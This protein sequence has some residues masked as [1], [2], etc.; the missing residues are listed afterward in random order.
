MAND[1]THHSTLEAEVRR[2]A[3]SCDLG[4]LNTEFFLKA[5]FVM[6]IA[7]FIQQKEAAAFQRGLAVGQSSSRPAAKALP[8]QTQIR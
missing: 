6:N 2:I 7:S 4:G 3:N 1:Q 8:E 5:T